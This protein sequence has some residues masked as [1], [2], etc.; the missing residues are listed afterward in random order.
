M[1]YPAE[2][3]SLDSAINL[4]TNEQSSRLKV[5]AP[6]IVK[7]FDGRQTVTVQVVTSGQDS[8][9]SEMPIPL[10]VD[11]PVQFPRGGGFA[12]TFPI[13]AGDE[14]LVVFSDRCIDGWFS[15]GSAGIPPDHRQHDLSDAMFIPGISSLKRV[16]GDFRNDA[17]V[18]RQLNGPGYVSIDDSGNVD[19]DGTL[20]T[21][22]CKTHFMKPVTMDATLDVAGMFTYTAGMTGSGGE[23]SVASIT[24]IMNI[25]GEVTLNGV[26]LSLHRHPENGDGGGIT[27]GPQN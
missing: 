8:D 5:S 27:D 21:V 22:H 24:G 13:K 23:G 20:L 3:A 16:I 25:T 19:I 17:I 7:S 14:G 2:N 12:L 15:S 11:V 4:A 18:M 10:L 26:K 1:L 6:A 9:G